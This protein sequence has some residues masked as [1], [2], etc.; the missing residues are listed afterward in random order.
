M[1]PV[2]ALAAA[3]V[4]FAACGGREAPQ[5]RALELPELL[6]RVQAE[7]TQPLLLVFWAT[8][9]EP[10]VAEIPDLAALHDPSAGRLEIL[11]VSLDAFLH[12]LDQSTDLVRKQLQKTPAPY[13]NVVFTGKQ[14]ALFAALD[15]PGGIPYAIL[16]DAQGRVLRRFTGQVDPAIVRAALA[17]G[18]GVGASAGET[19]AR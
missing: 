5:P 2:A 9:C 11:G 16:Y 3:A 12:P 13:E 7:R 6:S 19:G 4:L 8:W 15:M 17:A 1:R 10:C 18:G 14:D